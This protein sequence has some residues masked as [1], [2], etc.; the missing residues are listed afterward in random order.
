MPPLRLVSLALGCALFAACSKKPAPPAEEVYSAHPPPVAPKEP[1]RIALPKTAWPADKQALHVLNRLAFGPRPGEVEALAKAGVAG[2]IGAQLHPAGINDAAVEAKLAKMPSL[3]MSIAALNDAYPRPEKARRAD[4]GAGGA[5][6]AA[7]AAEKPNVMRKE[8]LAQKVLRATES[9][10][11]LQEVLVDFWFNHFNVNSDKG[12]EERWF[13]GPYERDAIRPHVFGRFRDLLGATAHHPALLFYAD[14]WLSVA[15]KPAAAGKPARGINEN[16]AR[17]LLELHT[18]GVDAGYTQ[19]DVTTTARALTG[20]SIEKPGQE[21]A[22]IFRPGAHDKDPKVI[23]GTPFNAGGQDD[24]ER[25]LDLLAAHKATAHH[26]AFELCQLFHSDKPP[27][28]MVDRV[29]G[30]FTKSGGDLTQVYE[31]I[32]TSPEMWSDDAYRTKIKTPFELVASA[33]R[34]VGAT[35]AEA[36]PAANE[37]DKLGEPLYRCAPPAGYPEVSAAW[38][39]TGGLLGRINFGLALGGGRIKG[40]SFD[41]DK[42]A[43]KPLPATDEALVD[44]LAEAVL[45]APLSAGTRATIVKEL[46]ESNG[47]VPYQEP[48]PN[49]VPLALGLLLGS[50]EMQKQ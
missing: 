25:L 34:A 2:W 27:D 28:A 35:I 9:E 24:G 3:T 47:S 16:Y 7:A 45:H 42:L 41:H 50:P 40:V 46:S 43:G 22:F 5:A 36:A 49:A 13:V 48:H 31:A 21:A 23:L 4:A 44:K 19:D 33:L 29:A 38:V 10:R 6:A 37:A 32:F 11:Q 39:S 20:W 17:A 26:L 1:V 14:Q 30:V 18:L 15:E 8:L 12:G